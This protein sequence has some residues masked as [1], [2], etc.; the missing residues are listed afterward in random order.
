MTQSTADAIDTVVIPG[1]LKM[2]QPIVAPVTV[3][4]P[5]YAR[6]SRWKNILL[7]VPSLVIAI[8]MLLGGMIL[9]FE[10]ARALGGD[11]S[12]RNIL[13]LLFCLLLSLFGMTFTGAGLTC[14]ADA[15]REAPVLVIEADGLH[16]TRSGFHASWSSIKSAKIRYLRGGP[17]AVDFHLRAPV[18]FWENPFRPGRLFFRLLPKPDQAIVPIAFLDVRS[19]IVMY[20]ILT[21]VREHGGEIS[22]KTPGFDMSLKL[23]PQ[24]ARKLA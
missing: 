15:T 16:D 24:P 20:T 4:L 14:I 13:G 10:G 5:L 11:F 23:L 17:G 7:G 12:A 3:Q 21:L 8:P 18:V 9:V 19:H 2:S 6:A 1:E 22:A